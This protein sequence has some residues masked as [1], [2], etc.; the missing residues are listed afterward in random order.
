MRVLIV[1]DEAPLRRLLAEWVQAEGAHVLEVRSA[2][3]ALAL[4][5]KEGPPAV[6]LCDVKL[7][8][9]NG[10]WLAEQFLALYPETAVIMTTAV[11]E[12]DA[13]VESLHAHVVDYL[14]KPFTH[15][16]LGDALKRAILIHQA[17][18]AHTA[19]LKELDDRRAQITEALAELELN[20]ASSLNAM[21]A[22]LQVRDAVSYDHAHRVAKLSVDLAMAMQIGEPQ[23]SDIERAALLHNLGRLAMPDDVLKRPEHA[24]SAADRAQLRSYPLHGYAMLKNVPMLA[25]ANEISVASHERYDG[26]GFPHGLRGDAIPLG[27]RIVGLADAYDELVAGIGYP[28]VSPARAIEIL[29]TDR[30]AHFDPHVLVALQTLQPGV[31]S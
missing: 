21:L 18:C 23:L 29:S 20:S 28:P 27:A 24:L 6:A 3:E 12:V 14:C 7:P 4:V 19:M 26:S 8:G 17:R 22:M 16:R 25:A 10:L 15:D 5:Q 2:E 11:H 9:R 31:A 30:A 1:E 13:A